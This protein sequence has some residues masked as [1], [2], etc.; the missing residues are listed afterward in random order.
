M[1]NTK[2]TDIKVEGGP[3]HGKIAS[4]QTRPLVTCSKDVFVVLD[5]MNKHR[6]PSF[7]LANLKAELDICRHC[8]V[9]N[10]VPDWLYK[11]SRIGAIALVMMGENFNRDNFAQLLVT[12]AAAYGPKPIFRWGEIGVVIRLD[13]KV[14][15]LDNLINQSPDRQSELTTQ[16]NESILDTMHDIL[17]YA[18]CGYRYLKGEDM[19]IDDVKD[20]DV[21]DV[22]SSEVMKAIF[23]RQHELAVKYSPIERKNGF[24]YPNGDE[25]IDNGLFQSWIK[26][27]FW[28]ATEEIA[29]ALEEHEH[30]PLYTDWMTRWEGD[31]KIR[32]FFEELADAMH[33]I[34]EAS[35]MCRIPVD[36]VQAIAENARLN[37]DLI[38][39]AEAKNKCSEVIYS[40]GLTANCL[41][42][43]PWKNSQMPT[44]IFKFQSC[45]LNVWRRW[46]QLMCYL[47][48]DLTTMYRLYMK[49][50]A[51]NSFRQR[52]NY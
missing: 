43:K 18:I 8:I 5:A 13:S 22:D 29:E 47:N 10:I 41:K 25:H 7:S 36:V 50:A 32:H 46:F 2:A 30:T 4:I 9:N 11:F 21:Q 37:S 27:M 49:K 16:L 12:K 40:M 17:G 3:Q 15:R 34:V 45:L 20:Q 33:F 23:D 19:N 1:D 35:L 24:W 26:N 28:R 52:T 6:L 14:D 48:V 39:M 44:D 51:V 38:K 42:N 31:S